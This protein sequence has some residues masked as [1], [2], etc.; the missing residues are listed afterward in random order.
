MESEEI[1][2]KVIVWAIEEYYDGKQI[3]EIC[4]EHEIEHEVFINWLKE[5]KCVALELMELKIENERLRKMLIDVI[6]ENQFQSNRLNAI[7]KLRKGNNL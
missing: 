4:R 3:E 2:V 5:Y 1:T 7:K 6:L